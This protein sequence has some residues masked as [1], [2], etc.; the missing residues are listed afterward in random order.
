VLHHTPAYLPGPRYAGWDHAPGR[1][2][3][4][5]RL[6]HSFLRGRTQLACPHISQQLTTANEWSM[7]CLHLRLLAADSLALVSAALCC[8]CI[9]S[10]CQAPHADSISWSACCGCVARSWWLRAWPSNLGASCCQLEDSCRVSTCLCCC[11]CCVVPAAIAAAASHA[12]NVSN[13]ASIHLREPCKG[14]TGRVQQD[15]GHTQLQTGESAQTPTA[16]SDLHGWYISLRS[17]CEVVP[18]VVVV[19]VVV[20]GC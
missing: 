7:R 5:C 12:L 13:A 1:Q 19:A 10:M 3:G 6:S 11:G 20:P 2:R 16:S 8:S 15:G 18:E 14:C 17:H 9:E 4:L